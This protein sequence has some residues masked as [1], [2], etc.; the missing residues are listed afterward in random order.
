MA[1]KPIA[2]CS[3]SGGLDSTTLAYWLKAEGYDLRL[4]T[5]DYGQRH[6]R[7]LKSAQMIAEEL[8]V[9]WELNDQTSLNKLLH[10]SALTDPSIEVPE[11]HYTLETQKL[12]V[13]PNR[14]MIFGS[15]AAG[16]A[17]AE[18]AQVVALGTH[19]SDFFTYPDCR[20]EFI[21]LLEKTTISANKGFL[22]PDFKILT[23]LLYLNKTDVLRLAHKLKVPIEKTWTCYNGEE[24]VCGKCGSDQELIESADIISR[25]LGITFEEAYPH[26]KGVDLTEARELMR[27]TSK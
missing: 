3:L 18:K 19:F 14:N 7:E 26:F 24:Q 15:I 6:R 27:A 20:P 10:G 17:V 5:F 4:I 11:G 8:G 23:P 21:E 12:T 25:E 9:P 1:Q 13:V 22:D 16:W 2:V